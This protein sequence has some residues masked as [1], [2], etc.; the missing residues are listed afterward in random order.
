MRGTAASATARRAARLHARGARRPQPKTSAR[1]GARAASRSAVTHEDA[2]PESGSDEERR[3]WRSPPDPSSRASAPA[4][5]VPLER[6]AGS[7]RRRRAPRASSVTS[8]SPTAPRPAMATR[9]GARAPR[10]RATSASP[11]T[12]EAGGT[13]A[14]T[15]LEERRHHDAE[16]QG[17]PGTDPTARP[18]SQAARTSRTRVQVQAAAAAVRIAARPAGVR[19]QLG[20]YRGGQERHSPRQSGGPAAPRRTSWRSPR[21]TGPSVATRSRPSSLA[22]PAPPVA[23]P[24]SGAARRTRARGARAPDL[25]TDPSSGLGEL[26]RA[27]QELLVPG[28]GYSRRRRRRARQPSDER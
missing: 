10:G 20:R 9:D 13:A 24:R 28:P 14:A 27:L 12:R 19:E 3:L 16:S 8:R 5:A 6:K 22:L 23:S 15:G 18:R 7:D 11:R 21:A 4:P 17:E 1:S 25:L 2:K 26:Q